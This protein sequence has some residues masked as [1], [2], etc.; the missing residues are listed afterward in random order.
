MHLQNY[1]IISICTY[2]MTD[3]QIT[4][5]ASGRKFQLLRLVVTRL[6]KLLSEDLVKNIKTDLCGGQIQS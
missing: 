4:I 2:I 1:Y 5:M 6:L 3:R